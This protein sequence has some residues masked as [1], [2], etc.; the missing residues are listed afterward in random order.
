MALT[1]T[2]GIFRGRRIRSNPQ[3]RHVRPTSGKVREALNNILRPYLLDASF[4]DLFAGNG[5]VGFEALSQGASH[6]TFV[7]NH[8]PTFKLLKEN[9]RE[10]LK[11]QNSQVG[12]TKCYQLDAYAFCQKQQL[13]DIVFADPPFTQSFE[14]LW[15]TIKPLVAPQG[16]GVI[17]F[18]SRMSNEDFPDLDKADS[19]KI[20]GESGL[21]FFYNR[22]A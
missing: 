19:I 22:E 21:A 1:I 11:G 2:G 12:S 3:S 8:G 10:L 5:S 17:Q 18:P 6:V 15:S 7:E 13:H 4:C 14:T 20:Y 9:E 16:V